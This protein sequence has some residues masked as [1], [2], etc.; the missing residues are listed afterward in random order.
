DSSLMI[1]STSSL[2]QSQQ[3]PPRP[4]QSRQIK[5]NQGKNINAVSISG[6][7]LDSPQLLCLLCKRHSLCIGHPLQTPLPARTGILEV[8]LQAMQFTRHLLL[9][10]AATAS[11]VALPAT[12][13]P[14][15]LLVVTVTTGF[16]HS[17]IE[18]GEKV[19]AELAQKSGDFTVDFVK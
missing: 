15:K 13:A 8:F 11:L 17:S 10:L 6:L 7:H 12:A 9:I 16:R 1:P 4:R 18:T 2:R 19:L 5:P 14:K 3:P